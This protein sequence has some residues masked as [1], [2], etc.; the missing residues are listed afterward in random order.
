MSLI[1]TPCV[2]VVSRRMPHRRGLALGVAIS[3]SSI[4]GILWPIMLQQLLYA[5][6]VSFG[7]VQRAVG[8]TMLPL[9]AIACL[10]VV[11]AEKESSKLAASESEILSEESPAGGNIG[12]LPVEEKP[13]AKHVIIVMFKNSAFILLCSGLGLVYFGLFTPFFYISTYAVDKGTSS[14]TAFY[15]ISAI[16]A[17]SF[18]GRIVPGYLADTYGHFNICALSV[19]TS[20]IIGFTWTAAYNLPGMIVWSIAYGF[21]SG[22][23]ISLQSACAA[24]LSKR[25]HQGTA[26][27]LLMGSVSVTALVG[28]P[29]SGQILSHG[30]YLSLG[31]WTGVTLI[32][33]GIILVAAR[34]KLDRRILMAY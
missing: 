26:L 21:A 25:E 17:A 7:W 20:G 4:G 27:G 9:L 5:D 1:L 22:A 29:I 3:G 32:V 18:F 23:V 31:I 2:A 6:G 15:L 19:L 10:T 13:K 16:N 28:T 24:K 14:S 8:F 30:G 12:E 33:G 34:L 11:D